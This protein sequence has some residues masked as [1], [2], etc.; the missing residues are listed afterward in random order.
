M[1]NSP[2]FQLTNLEQRLIANQTAKES[3]GNAITFFACERLNMMGKSQAYEWIQTPST[4]VG[5]HHTLVGR[6]QRLGASSTEEMQQ[7]NNI[8]I[9]QHKQTKARTDVGWKSSSA[10]GH[11]YGTIHG[12]V[13]D[14]EDDQNKTKRSIE[15]Q[16]KRQGSQ[17]G[18]ANVH[19]GQCSAQWCRAK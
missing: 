18:I 13:C 12:H 7:N 5:G 16:A 15:M 3:I 6:V 9:A 10:Q 11:Q 8:V 1:P 2:V 14:Q 19:H 4:D 17:V